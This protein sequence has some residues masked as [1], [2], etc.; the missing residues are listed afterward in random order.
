MFRCA[1]NARNLSLR[2]AELRDHELE[3]AYE[4]SDQD[5]AAA[6]AEFDRELSQ[7]KEVLDGYETTA[8]LSTFHSQV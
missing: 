3:L 7:I 4:R 1:G 5:I 2:P 8:R 6:K